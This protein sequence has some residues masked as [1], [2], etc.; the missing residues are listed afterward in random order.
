[1]HIQPLYS[2]LQFRDYSGYSVVPQM[3]AWKSMNI[4]GKVGIIAERQMFWYLTKSRH[5]III[6]IIIRTRSWLRTVALTILPRLQTQHLT[7]FTCVLWTCFLLDLTGLHTLHNLVVLQGLLCVTEEECWHQELLLL[8]QVCLIGCRVAGCSSR[9]LRN[10]NRRQW[11]LLTLGASSASTS[12]LD[13]LH[14]CGML[15]VVIRISVGVW[16]D[17]SKQ[18]FHGVLASFHLNSF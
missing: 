8:T 2:L 9:L 7:R 18:Q 4:I 12:L 5:Q 6:I 3:Y 13:H 10:A 17:S 11:P 16:Q 14:Y 1:M 15:L